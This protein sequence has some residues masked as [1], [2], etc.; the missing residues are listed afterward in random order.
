MVNFI[1][2]VLTRMPG[3][4]YRGWFGPCCSPS[5]IFLQMFTPVA[6]TNAVVLFSSSRSPYSCFLSLVWFLA[7]LHSIDPSCRGQSRTKCSVVVGAT[8]QG[9][10]SDWP[11][12][13]LWRRWAFRRL[14]SLNKDDL[15]RIWLGSSSCLNCGLA[16]A[17]RVLMMVFSS[18][19]GT[20]L[21]PCRP[22]EEIACTGGKQPSVMAAGG[23]RPR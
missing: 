7:V 21:S 4:S 5:S 15:F 19:N 6:F 3:G 14:C 20:C 11:I 23:L 18:T 22:A 16:V 9:H 1:Y 8:L 12:F 13:S 2:L 17:V 10:F